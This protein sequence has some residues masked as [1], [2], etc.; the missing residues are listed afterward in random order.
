M[1]KRLLAGAMAFTLALGA[2][3]LPDGIIEK[4]AIVL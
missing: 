3:T 2:M 1:L 4:S